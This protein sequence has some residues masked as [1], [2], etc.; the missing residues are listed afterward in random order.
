MASASGAVL[1]SFVDR[2]ADAA[3]FV[4]LAI[5]YRGHVATLVIPLAALVAS[6]LVS[7]ARAKADGLGLVLPNG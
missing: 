4:G 6:S 2:A 1:D 5:F 3:P 7:Y